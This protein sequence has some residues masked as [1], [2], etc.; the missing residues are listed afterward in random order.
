VWG[1]GGILCFGQTEFFGIG[2]YAYTIGAI[3]FG[4]STWAILVAILV[5]APLAALL[6]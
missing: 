3:N 5:V 2:A 4:G 1:F 6:G